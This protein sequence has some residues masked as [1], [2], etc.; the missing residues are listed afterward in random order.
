MKNT[1][2]A[3]KF[4]RA[5]MEV[6]LPGEEAGKFG[7]DLQALN[8]VFRDNP[9]LSRALLNPMNKLDERL[10]FMDEISRRVKA[11]PAVAKFMDILVETRN[12]GLIKEIAEA[13]ARLDDE[14]TGRLRAAI[15]APAPLPEDV[16]AEIRRRLEE[17]TGKDVLLTFT[18]DPSL[19]GGLVVKLEN[20]VIDGSLRTQLDIL[21]ERLR[22]GG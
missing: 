13:Y 6:G 8:E 11:S 4:A 12:I 17:I 2:A 7:E 14:R 20:T 10:A 15:E 19:I 5:L 21:R 1:A 3:R 18:V 22:E 16:L 9:R